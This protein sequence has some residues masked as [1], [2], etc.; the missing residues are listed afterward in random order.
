MKL[1][2]VIER[3]DATRANDVSE[4]MKTRWVNEVEGRVQCEV[5]RLPP[6]KVRFAKSGEDELCVPDPYA[7]LYTIYLVAM[8]E[9]SAGNYGDFIRLMTEFE[10]DLEL[11]AKWVVRNS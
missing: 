4:E 7:K 5:H 8:L 3:V 11:Y 2:E 1:R 9:F 10:K 6:V